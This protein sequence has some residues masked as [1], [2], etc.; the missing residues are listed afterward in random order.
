[1]PYISPLPIRDGMVDL[2]GIPSQYR[3]EPIEVALEDVISWL[4]EEAET[5]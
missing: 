3:I 5:E 2:S 1:M 4:S